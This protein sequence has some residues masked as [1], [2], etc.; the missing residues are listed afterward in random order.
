M[1]ITHSYEGLSLEYS[2]ARQGTP[3]FARFMVSHSGLDI[4]T[5]PAPLNIVELGVGSGQQTEFV[6]RELVRRGLTPYRILA[7][8]K[9][10]R[11]DSSKETGQLNLLIDRI[12][13]GE[14]SSC[15]FPVQL[16][17]DGCPLPLRSSCV[18]LTYMAW[19]FH[20]LTHKQAV[21]DEI[22]RVSRS[23]AGLFLYQ[24]TIEDLEHHPLNEF[25][26]TKYSCD[27]K[28][29]PTLPQLRE[30][31]RGAGFS[32]E[33]PCVVRR[34][35]SL[36]MDRAFLRFVENTTFDSALMMIR[37]NDPAAF[38]EGVTRVKREVEKGELSGRYR[39]YH[40]IDRKVFWG[41]KQ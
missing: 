34:D 29:Y 14:I 37:D 38:A 28:R 35:A 19:V 8:D 32:F 23:G 4:K 11:A 31:F 20:H 26:P 25:F 16:D 39:I 1:E 15:V 6:E 36:L 27:I 21:L 30:M 33:K 9:S 22:A 3:R 13:K 12:N 7:Y 17:F 2:R 10:F 5:R 18:D 41:I 40:R 24:V